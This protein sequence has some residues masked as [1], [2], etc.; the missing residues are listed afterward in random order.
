MTVLTVQSPPVSN[1]LLLPPFQ[2]PQSDQ[3]TQTQCPNAQHDRP[4]YSRVVVHSAMHLDSISR[5]VS[6][7]IMNLLILAISSGAPDNY[8]ASSLIYKLNKD[9]TNRITRN[10][11]Y[12][13]LS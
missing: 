10:M 4:K 11:N 8:R 9:H 6:T 5:V 7:H 13:R 12:K 2:H 3:R 1:F